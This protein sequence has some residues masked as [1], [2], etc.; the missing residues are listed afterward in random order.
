M[1]FLVIRKPRVSMNPG[2]TSQMIRAQKETLLN[3]V[4]EAVID[5]TYAFIGGG[6]FGI[7][8]ANSTEELNQ[9]IMSAPMALYYD[10]EVRALTDYARHM[11][12]VATA[13]EKQGR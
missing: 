11:D 4:K 1:K 9:K 5:C 10:F 2:P 12:A 6:G 7:A 3:A 13:F 8:N